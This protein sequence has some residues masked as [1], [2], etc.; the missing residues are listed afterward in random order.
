MRPCSSNYMNLRHD[1]NFAL[2]TFQQIKLW[3]MKSN[4]I[5]CLYPKQIVSFF[6]FLV[7]IARMKRKFKVIFFPQ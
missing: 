2:N 5:L 7:Y 6:F 4:C 1:K 3:V